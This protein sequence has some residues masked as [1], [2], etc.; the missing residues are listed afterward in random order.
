MTNKG[1]ILPIFVILLPIL[2]LIIGY[3]VDI[4]LIYTEKR[5]ITNICKDSIIYY[6]DN[7]SNSNVYD[8]TVEYINKNI[9]NAVINI[10]DNGDSITINIKEKRNGIYNI[11]NINTEINITYTGY[12]ADKR[13]IKG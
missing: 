4:G 7:E 11:I 9:K 6:I 2:I 12:K 8:N 10:R 3:V 13:I 1:Q 5:R